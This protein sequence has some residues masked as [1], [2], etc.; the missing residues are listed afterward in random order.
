MR[1]L[2]PANNPIYFATADTKHLGDYING[3]KSFGGVRG[4]IGIAGADPGHGDVV[5]HKS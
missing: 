1:K 2:A 3:K 4:V 5:G